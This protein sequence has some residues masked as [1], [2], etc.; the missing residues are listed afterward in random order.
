M[1]NYQR[2]YSH[3][4]SIIPPFLLAK[5][6]FG[7]SPYPWSG[8]WPEAP[9]GGL[10][11]GMACH[12]TSPDGWWMVAKSCTIKN[13]GLSRFIPLFIGFQH[14]STILSVISHPST[15]KGRKKVEKWCSKLY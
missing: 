14:V 10:R 2:V 13:G 6:P 15:E 11:L 1:L 5:S 9:Q 12:L 7:V 4:I 3:C 8:A